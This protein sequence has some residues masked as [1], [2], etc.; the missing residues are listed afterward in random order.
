[1]TRIAVAMGGNA[2]IRRGEPG[3]IDVQRRN[4]EVAARSLVDLA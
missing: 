2:M 1:M 4:L 3:S